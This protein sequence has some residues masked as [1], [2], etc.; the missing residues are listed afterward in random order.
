MTVACITSRRLSSNPLSP[1]LAGCGLGQNGL[2]GRLLFASGVPTEQQALNPCRAVRTAQGATFQRGT[3]KS[4]RRP[5][6]EPEL[7]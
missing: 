6:A 1:A 2:L 4:M 3:P 7:A 5:W